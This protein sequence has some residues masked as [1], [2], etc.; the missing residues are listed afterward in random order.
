MALAIALFLNILLSGA[1]ARLLWKWLV[2][3]KGQRAGLSS[4]ISIILGAVA[5]FVSPIALYWLA[6]V[7]GIIV[8]N[9]PGRLMIKMI[10]IGFWISLLGA[11]FGMRSARSEESG[12]RS[13]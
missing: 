5:G 7:L 11:Y 9:E 4:L 2:T 13:R 12:N 8:W 3:T 6:E 10:G 1:A